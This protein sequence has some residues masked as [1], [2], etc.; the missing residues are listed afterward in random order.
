MLLPL[1]RPSLVEHH[2]A[3]GILDRQLPQH[4]LVHQSEDRGVG[5]DAQASERIATA[6]NKGL[7]RMARKENRKSGS[8]LVIL[9]QYS[10]V[11]RWF[12]SSTANVGRGDW[13]LG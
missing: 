11:R 5:A 1:W 13:G 7:R 4:E 6:A 2:Q 3:V 12:E 10:F 8:R 9:V